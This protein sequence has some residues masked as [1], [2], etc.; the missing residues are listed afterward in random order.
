MNRHKIREISEDHYDNLEEAISHLK[1]DPHAA[2]IHRFRVECKKQR[3]F[4]RMLS[5]ALPGNR[6]IRITKDLKKL[7]HLAGIIREHQL[8]ERRVLKGTRL[9]PKP[10][11]VYL[12][13]LQ[14]KIDQLN[15]ALYKIVSKDLLPTCRKMTNA[16]LPSQF[17]VARFREYIML[18][19][20]SIYSVLD[21][22]NFSDRNIHL[23]RKKM[24]DLHY[25]TRYFEGISPEQLGRIVWKGKDAEWIDKLLTEL[26]N[27]QDRCNSIALLR[28]HW[29]N[30]FDVYNKRLLERLK[31]EW[32]E[33]KLLKKQKILQKLV[34][35]FCRQQAVVL[36]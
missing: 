14:Q 21:S 9:A 36:A 27:F 19:W 26:G 30:K 2:A 22:R 16:L 3:A 35:N 12:N 31:K 33:D 25:N 23:I 15:P 11:R 7:Y 4:F 18:Q 28:A 8:Q 29:L 10:P 34:N 24:K 1:K 5:E 6:R 20:D 13:L 32:I 17:P